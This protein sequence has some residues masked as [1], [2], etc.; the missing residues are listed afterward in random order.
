MKKTK[1]TPEQLQTIQDQQTKL[2]NLLNQI[3]YV[4]AQKHAFLHEFADVNMKV[5]EYKK[6]LEKQYGQINI[7][8]ED[9]TYTEIKE[10]EKAPDLKVVK[11]EEP[12]NV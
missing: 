1:I 9:G 4:E 5:E 3:G 7:N 8:V 10:E 12:A 11:E 2:N 6:E